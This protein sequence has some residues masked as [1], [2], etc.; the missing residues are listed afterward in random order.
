LFKQQDYA[1]ASE[2]PVVLNG[3]IS[4]ICDKSYDFKVVR[5][6]VAGALV[7]RAP[8]LYEMA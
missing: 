5:S 8:D 1:I 2:D 6:G 3:R 4:I 7:K